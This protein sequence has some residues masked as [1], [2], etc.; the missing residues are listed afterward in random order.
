MHF[1]QKKIFFFQVACGVAGIY[2]ATSAVLVGPST[3][4]TAVE[5]T[6]FVVVVRI[7]SFLKPP[8]KKCWNC[9]LKVLLRALCY[10]RS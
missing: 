3:A 8:E 4:K 7:P 5:A 10:R 6:F 2:S 1:V 9:I